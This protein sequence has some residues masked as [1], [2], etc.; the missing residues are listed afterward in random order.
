MIALG[1]MEDIPSLRTVH[2]Q[3]KADTEIRLGVANA[4]LS[5][6]GETDQATMEQE[7]DDIRDNI[8]DHDLWDDI[9]ALLEQS[10]GPGRYSRLRRHLHS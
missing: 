1:Q 8:A 2:R 10:F 9:W 3:F 5:I 7:L 6:L 4:L